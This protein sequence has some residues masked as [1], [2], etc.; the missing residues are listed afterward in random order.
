M[1][2]RRFAAS[3]FVSVLCLTSTV[4]LGPVQAQECTVKDKFFGFLVDILPATYGLNT[5]IANNVGTIAKAVASTLFSSC[6]ALDIYDVV[7]NNDLRGLFDLFKAIMAK[8]SDVSPLL[9][10]YMLAQ[11]DDRVDNLCDA[12]SGTFGPC[13]EK[14]IPKLL[15]ELIKDDKCCSQISD[16]LEMLNIIVPADKNLNYFIVNELI[17]GFNRFLCSKRGK[18]S[19]GLEMFRQLTQKYKE[20]EFDFFQH[21]VFPFMTIGPGEECSGLSGKPFTDT[22]SK[23]VTTIINHGCCVHHMRPFIQ[24]LQTAIKYLTGSHTWDIVGGMVSFK[25]PDGKFVDTLAG[26]TTCQF[27]ERCKDPKGMADDL[28]MTRDP[29]SKNPGKNDVFGTDCKLVD[30]CD[31]AKSICSQVCER[32][33]VAVPEWLR[34][35]LAYQ[36]NLAIRSPFCLTQF[37]ASH[38]SAITLADGFGNRDQL[39]NRNLHPDRWWSYLKTN[40]QVLSL[41]DQLNVGIRFVEIDTHFFLKQLRTGHCGTL[42]LETVAGFFGALGKALGNYGT[43]DWGPELLG[44]FPSI[45]GI[46]ASEQPLT[47][48]ALS[49]IKDWLDANPEE[50]LI[51]YLDTGSDIKRTNKFG[52]IDTLL[53]DVFGEL[54]VP[55]KE[56]EDLAANKW[57]GKSINLFRKAGFRVL[58]LT[59]TKTGVAYNMF[60]LCGGSKDLPINFINDLPDGKRQLGG[61]DI[62]SRNNWIRTWSDQLRYISMA[63]SGTI[64][65]D[66][67]VFLD[68]E[69]IPNY[70]RWNLNLIAL[71]NVD[72]AKIAAHVWS[73]ADKEPSTTERGAYALMNGDG[74]WVTSTTAKKEFR[75]CWRSNVTTW[76]LVP[77]AEECPGGSIYEPP[78]DPYQNYLLHQAITTK[79]VKET[80]VVINAVVEST[81]TLTPVPVSR[82]RETRDEKMEKG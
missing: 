56:L 68:A 77:F 64:T 60:D 12:F 34:S 17:D 5:C 13:G 72:V 80:C 20:E 66:F 15:P 44:C 7:K 28:P 3:I 73:W 50:F 62:Y 27:E 18:S 22:A 81:E 58:A 79:K 46:E 33:S 71:D 78:M 35:T 16:V 48:N 76:D 32:G 24:T 25:A 65:R 11:N 70:L 75:A 51:V 6:S 69:S 63:A 21:V 30:K 45:S 1:N 14:V 39:F 59:N 55:L 9:Y 26:T 36:R 2:L 10:K 38:N 49:E 61:I 67:P 74:R 42:G 41:T 82:N 37:P 40:N 8:P 23:A 52:D 29:G 43:Y 53:T 57:Q 4:K 47:L 54:I 31:A 19:C